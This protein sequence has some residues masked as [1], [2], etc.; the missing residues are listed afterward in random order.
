M[1]RRLI[2]PTRKACA[3]VLGTI[4]IAMVSAGALVALAV[5]IGADRII[6]GSPTL[7]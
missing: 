1:S 5:I 4:A 3:A 6:G 2:T 7:H